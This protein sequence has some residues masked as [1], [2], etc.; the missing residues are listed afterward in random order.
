[1]NNPVLERELVGVLRTQ[2]AFVMQL[3]SAVLLSLL[4]FWGWPTDARA[5]LSGAQAQQVFRIFGYGLAMMLVLLIPAFPATSIV[6]DKQSR[7]LE[8][9]LISPMSP[10]AIFFAKLTG[11]LGFAFLPLLMSIPAACACFVMGGL[12]LDDLLRL[13]GIL[14]LLTIQLATMGLW[15]SSL[16][17]TADSSLRTTYGIMF[18]M[19]VATLGPYQFVHGKPWPMIVTAALWIRSLSPLPAIMELLGHGDVGLQ[20]LVGASGAPFRYA[21]LAVISSVVSSMHTLSRLNP[22]IFDSSRSQGVITDDRSR[23]QQWYRR[24][25]FLVDPQRRTGMIGRFTNPVLVREFRTRR[26][27]RSHWTLRI[28][29]LCM[30]VSLGLTYTSSTGSSD[31]GPE[32]VSGLMVVLQVGLILL[33]TPGLAAGLISTER[34]SGGL[35]LLQVTPLSPFTILSG[36]LVSAALTTTLILL[37][38]IPGYLVMIYITSSIRQQILYV[39]ICLLLLAAFSVV[40]STLVG[41]YCRRTA[42]ATVASY[43]IL[44]ALC[45]GTMLFWLGGEAFS[46]Q[47]I[48]FLLMSNP[49]AAAL[50]IME[51]RGF[52]NYDLIP[53]N[54]WIMGT[55]TVAMLV[56]LM[57]RVRRLLLPQ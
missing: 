36:K 25:M 44:A 50:S 51:V 31:W 47:T 22:R 10:S 39:L 30:M 34:E 7:T 38:T 46:H 33:L 1:M 45:G 17:Q 55:A 54:W 43:A 41:S 9:M 29:A 24:L 49:M 42:T 53:A 15:V 40:L 4:V 37:A 14:A 27:G 21:V 5:D 18:L 52:E 12:N 11:V 2:K 32:S 57:L 23:G 6:R 20:G 28:I 3:G 13:Y 8:L 26:F 16:S 48:E 56:V 19:I 35:L